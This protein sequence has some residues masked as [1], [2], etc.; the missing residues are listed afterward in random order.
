MIAKRHGVG[1]F[2]DLCE[3][4]EGASRRDFQ[5]GDE[6]GGR[7]PERPVDAPGRH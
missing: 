3:L 2:C 7:R 1:P 6:A 5:V 4:P